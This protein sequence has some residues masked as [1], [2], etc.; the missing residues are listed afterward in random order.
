VLLTPAEVRVLGCLVEKQWTTPD[1]YPLTRNALV[2]A[3]NQSTNRDPIVSYDETLV[4]ETLF[5]LQEQGLTRT[6]HLPGARV[7]KHRHVLDEAWGVDR[8]QLSLLSVLMLRGPQT[9]G[10]LKIRVE[11][12]HAFRTPD[13]VEVTLRELA[14][15]SDPFVERQERRPG[16]KE[17]RW[18]HLLEGATP[19]AD[20]YA[21]PASPRHVG[22]SSPRPSDNG[23]AAR[24]REEVARLTGEVVRLG[25]ELAALRTDFERFRA[26]F[27]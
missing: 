11:R 5:G 24:D 26:A 3:C 15:R 21:E 25:E 12:L 8:P 6:V 14:A 2:L 7:P 18:T 23:G 4:A 10:E 1:Q 20:P 16:Q 17:A 19:V 9:P 22:S 27:E 13:D